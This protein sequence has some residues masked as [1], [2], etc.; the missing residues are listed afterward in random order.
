[1]MS[2]KHLENDEISFQNVYRHMEPVNFTMEGML[3][4]YWVCNFLFY[5]YPCIEKENVMSWC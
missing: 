3:I 4:T 2:E 1:M 5:G